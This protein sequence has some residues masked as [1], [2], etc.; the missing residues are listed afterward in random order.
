MLSY[1]VARR[2]R[3]IGIR[4]ALGAVQGDVLGLILRMAARLVLIGLTVGLV[5]GLALAKLLRSEVFQVPNTD[6]AAIG[7]AVALLALAACLACFGPAW[8]AA[9]LDPMSSLRHD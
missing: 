4:I 3:E 7:G 8:R 5:G 9:R 2:T 1:T 6:P